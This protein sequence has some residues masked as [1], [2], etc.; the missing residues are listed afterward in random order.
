[1][2]VD[3]GMRRKDRRGQIDA[4]A[5]SLMLQNYLDSRMHRRRRRE[6][7]RQNATS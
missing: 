5:A 7:P 6:D 1:M 2:L 3:A 4:L